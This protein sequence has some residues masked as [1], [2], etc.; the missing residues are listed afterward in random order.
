MV[1][2]VFRNFPN[3][4][5]LEMIWIS[6]CRSVQRVF[7]KLAIVSIRLNDMDFHSVVQPALSVTR[8][9][10]E[11]T[12]PILSFFPVFSS[13]SPIFPD[14]F[15]LFPDFWHFFRC[16]GLHSP[17]LH[18]QWLRHWVA[19]VFTLAKSLNYDMTIRIWWD[20]TEY[21][22]FAE[23]FTCS[24]LARN[25]AKKYSVEPIKSTSL[26]LCTLNCCCFVPEWRPL[27]VIV[28]AGRFKYHVE[29]RVNKMTKCVF[30][31]VFITYFFHTIICCFVRR[32]W[33]CNEIWR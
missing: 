15:P 18:P 9:K 14:F 25:S 2:R 1:Q 6:R 32:R 27:W 28:T 16:Q 17:P 13:F 5:I 11:K 30:V 24:H 10:G 31:V 23:A 22:T 21:S 12:F 26:T 8:G 3:V 7:C 33:R 29:W 4:S 19:T 20:Q